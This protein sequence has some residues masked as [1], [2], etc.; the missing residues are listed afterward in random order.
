MSITEIGL[1]Y[2]CSQ[3]SL[4]LYINLISF[5]KTCI[6]II[7]NYLFLYKFLLGYNYPNL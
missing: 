5:N 4:N 7:K 6:N 1:G 3:P 2:N